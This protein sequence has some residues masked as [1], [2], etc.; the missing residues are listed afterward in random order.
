M[1]ESES[2]HRPHLQLGRYVLDDLHRLIQVMRT[3]KIAV[4]APDLPPISLYDAE[5]FISGHVWVTFPSA[6]AMR[7]GDWFCFLNKCD[8][9]VKLRFESSR[10]D[11]SEIIIAQRQIGCVCVD[12][13]KSAGIETEINLVRERDNGSWEH[14]SSGSG[15]GAK[16]EIVGP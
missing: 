13:N 3:P 7:G 8:T 1:K 9:T 16:M 10:I 11:P 2:S 5:I 12:E 6:L 14:V 15:N 4:Q